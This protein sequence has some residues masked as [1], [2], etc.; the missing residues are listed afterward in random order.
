MTDTFTIT[1]TARSTTYTLSGAD[2]TTG[3]TIQYLGDQGFGLAPMHRITT[4]GPLQEGD[5]DIDFRL[6]PRVMQLPLM[7]VNTSATPRYQ[8]YEIREKLLSIFRPGD[9]GIISVGWYNGVTQ[10]RRLIETRVLGGLS[11]D[12]DPNGYHIRTVVQLRASDPTWYDNTVNQVTYTQANI[13]GSQVLTTAG[14]WL[15]FPT[16]IINGPITNPKITN[17]TTGQYIELTTTVVLGTPLNIDL[18]YGQKTVFSNSPY[19]NRISTVTP[20]SSLATWSL[21]PGNN[22]ISITGTGTTA[23]TSIVFSYLDRYTGI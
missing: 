9:D 11:F 14:N 17:N 7:V 4:R 16:I 6:D 19:V 12:V 21:Q 10:K 15:S 23:A 1:Y 22:T 13:G 20:A 18:T 5:S 3:L 2:A 8:H